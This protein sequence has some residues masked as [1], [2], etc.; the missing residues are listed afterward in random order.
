MYLTI[1]ADSSQNVMAETF[2][3]RYKTKIT[4]SSV[5]LHLKVFLPKAQVDDQHYISFK[6]LLLK[7]FTFN[8]SFFFTIIIIKS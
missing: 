6:I 7:L 3:K 2:Q 1:M 8:V 5:Q 4:D